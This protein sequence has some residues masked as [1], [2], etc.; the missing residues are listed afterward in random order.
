MATFLDWAKRYADM[1]YP[2][3]PVSR[4]K[5]PLISG[6]FLSASTDPAQLQEWWG[7]R[8][9]GANIGLAVPDRI[10][11]VDFD[12]SQAKAQ[13]GA[14]DMSL[15]TTVAQKTPRGEHLWYSAP[16]G[17]TLDW[18]PATDTPFKGIDLRTR[19]SYVVVAP[20]VNDEDKTYSW[21]T[22]PLRESIT[23][24]PEWLV[25]IALKGH[26]TQSLVAKAALEIDSVLTGVD[27]G[28]RD[29]TLFRLASKL[30]NEGRSRAEV[31]ALILHAAS[32]C[33]P[34]FPAD[35]ALEKV[36]SAWKYTPGAPTVEKRQHK[37]WS[38]RE[39]MTSDFPEPHWV[40]KD[41]MP[42]G[43]TLV[44]AP[45]KT[46][47]SFL[48]GGLLNAQ[49][50]G[51]KAFG[52]FE[53]TPGAGICLDLEQG[54][55]FAQQRWRVLLDGADFP[56]NLD[57][58][59]SWDRMDQGGLAALEQEIINNPAVR[60][61]VI[62]LLA[63]FWPAETSDGGNAYHQEYRILTQLGDLARK[64]HIAVVAVHHTNKVFLLSDPMACVSGSAA[65]TGVPD[66]I[67]IPYRPLDSSDAKIYVTGKNV[68][69]QWVDMYAHPD[70][71]VWTYA[72]VRLS[73]PP[74][75]SIPVAPA[76]VV[77]SVNDLPEGTPADVQK[78]IMD[79]FGT[80]TN[81]VTAPPL[82]P[83]QQMEIAS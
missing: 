2:V 74:S 48:L 80:F 21:I 6:G 56:E 47:K 3:F 55:T 51:E 20:S 61:V 17:V 72:G 75:D 54:P 36:E 44:V 37:K 28:Q 41:L 53:T 30:R 7:K 27:Q 10:C 23:E 14:L 19:G 64:Y 59:F 16:E 66:T 5:D 18:R 73:S 65:M 70:T 15:P 69:T 45:P 67:W 25:Q 38:M 83:Q 79:I 12:N 49:A 11:V 52:Y 29:F 78:T 9:P 32:N 33:Q 39:L 13:L 63:K 60:I 40:V 77:T 1:G 46:G 31:E 57:T 26:D 24:A 81:V 35:K 42:E 22:P 8:W 4:Q 50:K 71:G 58:Y 62:D 34:P 68:R 82:Q 43:L 76:T